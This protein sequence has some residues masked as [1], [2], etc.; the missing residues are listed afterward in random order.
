MYTCATV[1]VCM[2]LCAVCISLGVKE[3]E[4]KRCYCIQPFALAISIA[5]SISSQ[6]CSKSEFL[7]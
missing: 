4:R 5:L 1:S 6:L 7:K 2:S 3:M